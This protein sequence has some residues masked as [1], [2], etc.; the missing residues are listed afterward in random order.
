M[1]IQQLVILTLSSFLA[2]AESKLHSRDLHQTLHLNCA[3]QLSPRCLDYAVPKG[4]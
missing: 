4:R 2:L 3:L 1:S